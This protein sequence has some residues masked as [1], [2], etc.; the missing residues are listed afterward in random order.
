MTH[1]SLWWRAMRPW[2][3]TVSVVPPILG[4]LIAILE[5]P[6]ITFSWPYLILM[7]VGCMAAHGG[8]NMLSDYYDYQH[9]VDREGTFGSSGLLVSRI[10]KPVQMLRAAWIALMVAG[11]IGM[12]FILALPNGEK[13]LFLI[14]I[15][16]VLGV[17]YTMGPVALKYHAIGD[18][19]VFVAFG[20]A[21]V[22][23]AYFVQAGRFSW[24][25]VLYAIPIALLVDAV[26]HSNNLRDIQNDSMV[27][28]KTFAIVIGEAGAKIMYYGLVFGAYVSIVFLIFFTRLPW[29]GLVT[30]L[31]LPLAVKL[32]KTVYNKSTI[33]PQQFA[34]IDASTA[35]LHSAFSV[36][37]I[38]SLLIQH[39]FIAA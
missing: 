31:S 28:I 30:F 25:P 29:I 33:H 39:L 22:L 35:Q 32:A 7:A 13:L 18:I 10:L 2:A 26:L 16:G 5:N 21:M 15:G 6:Q 9:R 37:L 3:F 27:N 20:P 34:M 4:S 12:Y 17:F 14:L 8:A 24:T 11:L 36:L 38:L 19:A 1:I 23:G